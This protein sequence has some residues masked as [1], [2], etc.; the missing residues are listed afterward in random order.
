[1]SFIK[2][3]LLS[4]VLISLNLCVKLK[5]KTKCIALDGD[6]DLTAFCCADY[7]CKDYRCSVKGTKDNQIE[8]APDGDKCNWTHTCKKN[9]SC[10]SHRC[11][12]LNSVTD[13]E[14]DIIKKVSN[15]LH[16]NE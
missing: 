6:C 7:V 15:V 14:E 12:L 16:D 1:M 11:V 9:Y 4:I 2:F 10:Q 8:W 3:F 5:S 13:E